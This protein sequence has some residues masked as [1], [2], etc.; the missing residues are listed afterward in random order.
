MAEAALF[1]EQRARTRLDTMVTVT[2]LQIAAE[3]GVYAHEHDVTQLLIVDVI[4]TVTSPATDTLSASMD[5]QRIA[6]D[7]QALGAQRT[8]LIET[9]ARLL[10]ERCLAHPAAQRV[11]VRVAKPGALRNGLAGTTVVMARL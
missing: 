7:A 11:E 2:G 3:I 6:D 9:Y 5:Y 4:V 8:G 1:A 10:A